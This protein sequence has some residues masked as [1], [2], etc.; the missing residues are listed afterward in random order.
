MNL[1]KQL[2]LIAFLALT[3]ITVK[4]QAQSPTALTL[5]AKPTAVA[6]NP[7][8]HVKSYREWKHELVVDAQG[9]VMMLKTQ[10]E[11]RKQSRGVAQ[12]TDPN[13]GKTHGLE[14]VASRD[15]ALE[16]LEKD[17]RAEQYD[18]DVANDLTVTDYFVGYLTK[19]QNKKAAFQE[20]A[21]KLSPDE[22]AELMTAYANSVFGAHAADLPASAANVAKDPVK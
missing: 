18:L 1:V 2:P 19:V 8:S 21:G 16:K 11:S 10:I 12:G 15:L 9:K 17:L 20:V 7:A 22:V 6:A 4:A 5:Q 14:A 13:L 3:A